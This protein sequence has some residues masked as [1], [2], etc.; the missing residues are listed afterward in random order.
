M[1]G[2]LLQGY[3]L[4]NDNQGECHAKTLAFRLG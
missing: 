1:L 2:R 3:A 4:R